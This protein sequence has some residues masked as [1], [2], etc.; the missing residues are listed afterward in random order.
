MKPYLSQASTYYQLSEPRRI[1]F[2]LDR[3]RYRVN[4]DEPQ[5]KMSNALYDQLN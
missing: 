5:I 3:H 1:L 2:A 4:L